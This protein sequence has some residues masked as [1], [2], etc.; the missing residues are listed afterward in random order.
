[1]STRPDYIDEEILNL[2][3]EYKVDTI[4]LGVQSLDDTVL[5]NSGRGHNS[6]QVYVASK[7]IKEYEFNLGLQ[8]MIGLVGDSREKAIFTGKEFVKLNPFCVRI[9]PTLVIKDTFLEKMYRNNIYKPLSLKEAVNISAHL[10]MLFEYYHINVI[11]VG[12]QP[13]ENIRL[14][15]DVVAGPFHPSFR[16]LVESYIYKI[17]LEKHLDELGQSIF[18]NNMVLEVNE[19]NISNIVGQ[20]SCNTKYLVER[21]KLKSIKVC[22][23]DIKKDMIKVSVDGVNS[24]ICRRETI[25]E[26][27]KEKGII[28]T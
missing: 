18:N 27:L 17:I 8:M 21:Y 4:E 11:R 3:K 9:Y 20:R 15:R 10:L 26:Y 25:E 14:G 28:W 7:L 2:L 1:M 5:Y 22:G 12:L 6:Q 19:K 16:Q 13:T 23:R 24:K